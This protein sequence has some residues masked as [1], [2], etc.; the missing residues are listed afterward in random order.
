MYLGGAHGGAA[1]RTYRLNRSVESVKTCLY[2]GNVLP[3]IIKV[4]SIWFLINV[5][6]IYAIRRA[7]LFESTSR[8]GPGVEC[9][10][11]LAACKKTSFQRSGSAQGAQDFSRALSAISSPTV[12]TLVQGTWVPPR[13]GEERHRHRDIDGL[14]TMSIPVCRSQE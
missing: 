9:L 6:F 5:F 4:V 14:P 7:P 11:Y 2:H 3:A 1:C 12:D 10:P 13:C 8:P